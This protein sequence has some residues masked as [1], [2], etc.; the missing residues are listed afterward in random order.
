MLVVDIDA[1]LFRDYYS[2]FVLLFYSYFL[3][4]CFYFFFFS[5]RRRH[6]RFSR[7]WSSDVCSS[8]L[9]VHVP[10]C[11][12]PRGLQ[13]AAPARRSRPCAAGRDRR[14][15]EVARLEHRLERHA[16]HQDRKSVV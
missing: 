2:C 9:A 4:L 16:V 13:L 14:A 15:C 3:S 12:E 7:D 1:D 8:D 11:A 5:S 6:T 10:P